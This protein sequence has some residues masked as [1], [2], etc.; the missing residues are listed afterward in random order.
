MLCLPLCLMFRSNIRLVYFK[1]FE[2]C[3]NWQRKT[4]DY[5]WPSFIFVLPLRKDI[6]NRTWS[7]WLGTC[8]HQFVWLQKSLSDP[9]CLYYYN[10]EKKSMRSVIIEGLPISEFKQARHLSVTVSDHYENLFTF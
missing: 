9:F 5:R 1:I 3:V 7:N 2:F 8:P 6:P 4:E 10:L